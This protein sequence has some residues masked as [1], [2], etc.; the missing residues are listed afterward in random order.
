MDERRTLLLSE[1]LVPRDLQVDA[2]AA[3]YR[4]LAP[5]R[6]QPAPGCSS[7]TQETLQ[8]WR[9]SCSGPHFQAAAAALTPLTQTLPQLLHHQVHQAPW[10]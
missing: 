4:S 1:R 6:A 9:E 7:F 3:V 5:V 2:P 8:Y 10:A